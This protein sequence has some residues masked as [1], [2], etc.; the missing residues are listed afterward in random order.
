MPY[1][2]LQIFVI[3]E[4]QV[5]NRVIGPKYFV[6]ERQQLQKTVKVLVEMCHP[7]NSFN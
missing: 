3:T 2:E 5:H 6:L 4:A 7:V 1:T